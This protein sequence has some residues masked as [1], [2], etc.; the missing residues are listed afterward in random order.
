MDITILKEFDIKLKMEC[1][2]KAKQI[3]KLINDKGLISKFGID[4][5]SIT[6]KLSNEMDNQIKEIF[7]KVVRVEWGEKVE[8]KT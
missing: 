2:K 5:D 7:K 6:S 4:I 8:E 3:V 1:N